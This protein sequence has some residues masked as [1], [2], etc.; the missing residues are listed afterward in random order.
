MANTTMKTITAAVGAAM[1]QIGNAPAIAQ[2]ELALEPNDAPA[3]APTPEL[4]PRNQIAKDIAARANVDAD[5]NAAE[6]VVETDDEGNEVVASAP[7]EEE[8]S[9]LVEEPPVELAATEPAAP[10][11]EPAAAN[12][13]DPEGEYTLTVDGKPIKFKGSQIVERGKQAL[14][15]ESA[16]DF[17]LELASKLLLEAQARAAQPP[18]GAAVVAQPAQPAELSD[19]QLAE[20]IQF[21]TKEQAAQAIKAIR[22]QPQQQDG[23]KAMVEKLPQVV[24]DQ[25]AFQSAVTW[26]QAEHGD[27][28]T[29]PYLKPLFFMKENE[30]RKA[31]DA[32]PYKEVYQEIAE[33][34][35]THF[36]KPKTAAAQQAAAPQTR[37][38]KQAAKAAAPAAPKLASARM[39]AA[40]PDKPKSREEIIAAM[41][42]ARGQGPRRGAQTQH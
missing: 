37:E 13:F 17:R 21:G 34:L 38:A 22:Q 6:T 33:G 11:P 4:N 25:I 20:I 31:G 41:A 30:M 5:V 12:A 19:E 15:K 35:R 29:D 24:Q 2:P 9:A 39:E 23:V 36:N 18:Q 10:A 42:A 1:K 3:V 16:A 27:L 32:R 26:V 8:E 28:L 14:Q 40:A 7:T